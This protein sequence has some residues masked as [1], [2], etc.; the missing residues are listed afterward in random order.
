VNFDRV[1]P[2]YRTLETIVFGSA[3]QRARIRWLRAIP[4]PAKALI[5]GEGDGRFVS[6]LLRV[7]PGLEVDCVD[8]SAEMLEQAKMRLGENSDVASGVRFL[9]CDIREWTPVELY[10]LVVTHFVLDCFD[11]EDVKL[12]VE[13]LARIS[14]EDATWLLAD[15]Q[16]PRT[17]LA[18]MHAKV[19]L[20]AMYIFFRTTA[21]LRTKELVDPTD[22]LSAQGFVCRSRELSRFGMLKSEMWL[23]GSGET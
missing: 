6:E 20:R 2:F 19:W 12:V 4:K 22:P 14:T 9:Q 5:I 3:L 13:K 21:G 1:A 7:H 10:D 23:R 17:A 18:R 16:I 11:A 15:F 8:A